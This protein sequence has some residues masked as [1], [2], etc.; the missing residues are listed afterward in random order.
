MKGRILDF[1]VIIEQDE[2][3]MFVTKVPDIQGCAT[4]GK[5]LSEVLERAKEAIELCLE[6]EPYTYKQNQ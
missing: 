3:G 4:Q 2:K 1:T 5:T 6:A